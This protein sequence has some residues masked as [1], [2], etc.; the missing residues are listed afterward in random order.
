MSVVVKP[1]N[2]ISRIFPTSSCLKARRRTLKPPYFTRAGREKDR[3]FGK[4]RRSWLA[5]KFAND[6]RCVAAELLNYFTPTDHE[7][8][9]VV[10]TH[11]DSD[12][13]AP[14]IVF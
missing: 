11:D 5:T 13:S 14:R 12:T 10:Y 7:N 3:E 2:T 9:S 4:V 1:T 8:V 6:W